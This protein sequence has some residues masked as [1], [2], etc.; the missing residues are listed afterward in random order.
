MNSPGESVR[1]F[2]RRQGEERARA[3]VLS[4]LQAL[5]RTYLRFA[6]HNPEHAD[7]QHQYAEVVTHVIKLLTKGKKCAE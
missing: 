6:R 3:E 4:E 1:E 7:Q 5:R 2:Y